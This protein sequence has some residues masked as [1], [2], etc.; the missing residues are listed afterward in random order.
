MK[1]EISFKKKLDFFLFGWIIN[2]AYK[3]Y[4]RPKYN[5]QPYNKLV[6]FFLVPQKILRI[7]GSVK[8]P[9][10]FTSTVLSAHNIKKGIMTDPGDNPNVYL[11]A[12]NGIVLGSNV[13]IGTGSKLLS[14]IHSHDDHSK[15]DVDPPIVIGNNVFIGANTII[16]RSIN[17]GDNVVIGAGSLVTRDIPSNSIAFGNPCKVVRK[18]SE[19][20]EDFSDVK[21]NK[22]I[23]NEFMNYFDKN[24]S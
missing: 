6:Y 21:F 9:V 22:T 11:E 24:N 15:Y 13:G 5:P 19:Y 7:N 20:K 23:P 10:H 1:T 18:L 8:W 14:S 12:N 4:Y 17:I 2:W 3:E 16:L